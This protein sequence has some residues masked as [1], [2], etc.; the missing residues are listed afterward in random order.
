MLLSWLL[1]GFGCAPGPAIAPTC[2]LS[3][4][5]LA[6]GTTDYEVGALAAYAPDTDCL[7]PQL[8]SIGGDSVVRASGGNLWVLQRTGGDA[9]R[10]YAPGQY[11]APES[12]WVVEPQGNAHD[13]HVHHDRIVVSLYARA[14]AAVLDLDGTELARIDLSASADAD[15]LPEAD[16]IVAVD[17]RVFLALQRL[18]RAAQWTPAGPGH[19]VELDL[20]AGA[21][22]PAIEVG[23]NP[24]LSAHPADPSMLAVLSGV[25]FEPDGDVVSIAPDAGAAPPLWTE[26]E[27]GYDVTHLVGAGDHAVLLGVDFV[28]GGDARLDCV[29][30]QTGTLTPGID[31]AAW[32]VDATV[33]DQGM[34]WVV[35]RTG[36]GDAGDAA[37]Y[38]VEPQTCTIDRVH[39]GF[40]L[41]PFSIAWIDA[42][43]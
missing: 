42:T 41:P 32:W 33:D 40:T 28:V 22:L 23:T 3:Q 6:I 21:A 38:R 36:W 37:L 2:D 39:D 5:H 26:A 9:I 17:D 1:L 29:D 27:L 43:P 8:A 34:V 18:D 20:D 4:P 7:D 14:E 13:L 11:L 16:R 24:K 30:V 35:S 10:R 12:E 15:G 25:Y 19:L 31:D